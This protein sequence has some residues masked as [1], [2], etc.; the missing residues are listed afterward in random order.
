[1]HIERE[2]NI[3]RLTTLAGEPTL[4][5]DVNQVL[6][7]HE[8]RHTPTT[9][10]LVYT[11]SLEENTPAVLLRRL[12]EVLRMELGA[13]E[14][15][16]LDMGGVYDDHRDAEFHLRALY[17]ILGSNVPAPGQREWKGNPIDGQ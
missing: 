17:R 7:L 8:R 10:D 5:L 9:G 15:G 16:R 3:L 1:M 12:A 14:W 6:L 2:A 4:G 11:F 13:R